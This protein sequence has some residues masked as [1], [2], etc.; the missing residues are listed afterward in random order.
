VVCSSFHSI[1]SHISLVMFTG[2]N[3]LF[4]SFL[5]GSYVHESYNCPRCLVNIHVSFPYLQ[6]FIIYTSICL[7]YLMNFFASAIAVRVYACLDSMIATC[8]V[9]SFEI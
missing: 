9:T 8:C 3:E 4:S 2:V 7:V 6:F 5:F 1:G